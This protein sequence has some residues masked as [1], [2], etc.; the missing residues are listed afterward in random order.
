MREG[1]AEALQR[2]STVPLDGCVT[3]KCPR[4]SAKRGRRSSSCSV[5][6]GE[7]NLC[8]TSVLLFWEAVPSAPIGLL[9]QEHLLLLFEEPVSRMNLRF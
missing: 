7:R 2:H 8:K 9:R 4:S 5:K 6:G 3:S 1:L